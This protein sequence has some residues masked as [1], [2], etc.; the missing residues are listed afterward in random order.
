VL[1][2]ILLDRLDLLDGPPAGRGLTRLNLGET[3][4][5]ADMVL[6]SAV[7]DNWPRLREHFGDQL[8]DRLSASSFPHEGSTMTWN[9]LALV[10]D[11]H[12]VLG[13]ELGQAVANQPALLDNDGVLAWYATT[14]HGDDDLADV[15][16]G[17][18]DDSTNARTLASMLLADPH[19]LGLGPDDV[20][21]RL[22]SLFDPGRT[23]YLPYQSGALE[24]L[25][26]GSPG[27]ALVRRF[28]EMVADLRRQGEPVYMHPRTY[29]PLVYAAVPA[30][31]TAR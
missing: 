13:Q 25:S 16:V 10:A 7:A 21:A 18:L 2:V 4:E 22:Q 12:P 19:N 28:W 29:F 24:A 11:R 31:R 27:N 26:D 9:R 5:P 23:W 8:I 30:G 3:L 1:G 15:L 14:R 6:L 17:R 20:Q